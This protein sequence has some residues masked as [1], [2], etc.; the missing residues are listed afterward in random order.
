MLPLPQ[1]RDKVA[2]MLHTQLQNRLPLMAIGIFS[3]LP[4]S[5]SELTLPFYPHQLH[6]PGEMHSQSLQSLMAHIP[7]LVVIMPADPRSIIESYRYAIQKHKG[8]VVMLEHRL[9]YE[10]NFEEDKIYIAPVGD[11]NPAGPIPPNA[12]LTF[13][14]LT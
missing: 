6:R 3:P 13:T 10:L 8:P 1:E 7:G 5:F 14:F 11:Y 2:S 4:F 9:L 12:F